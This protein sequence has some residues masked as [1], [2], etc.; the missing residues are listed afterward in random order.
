M[1]RCFLVWPLVATLVAFGSCSRTPD[2]RPVE[3]SRLK[4][5]TD[6]FWALNESGYVITKEKP[7]AS[8]HGCKPYEYLLQKG[9]ARFRLSVFECGDVEQARELTAH[10]YN[11][12]V[13]ELLRNRK[14]GGIIQRGPLQL[15]LRFLEGDRNAVPELVNLLEKL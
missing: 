13:D 10:P 3:D 4:A 2:E 6:V 11:K 15:I 5:A 12:R 8:S 9:S 7:G 14:E 1:C